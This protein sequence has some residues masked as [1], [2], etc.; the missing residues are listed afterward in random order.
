MMG[1]FDDLGEEGVVVAVA[2]VGEAR[3]IGE[4]EGFEAVGMGDR[5]PDGEG[6]S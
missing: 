4:D 3:G 6:G 1:V 2:K 5:R